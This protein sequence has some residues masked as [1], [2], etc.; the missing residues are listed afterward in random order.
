MPARHRPALLL[1]GLLLLIVV[2]AVA[3]HRVLVTA[4]RAAPA[5][6]PGLRLVN[7]DLRAVHAI[8]L[9]TAAGWGPDLLGHGVLVSGQHARLRLAAADCV[10]DVRVVFADG[11]ALEWRQVDG[12][13]AAELVFP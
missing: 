4:P 9:A 11:G 10:R 6:E 3:Q 13:A 5:T 7:R 2:P 12:C 1:A 8:H